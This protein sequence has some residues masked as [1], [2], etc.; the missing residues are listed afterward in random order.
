MLLDGVLLWGSFVLAYFLRVGF[1]FS[2]DVVF[3]PYALVS[4]FAS[5]IWVLVLML[6]RY[7]TIPPMGPRK[8]LLVIALGGACATGFL[9]AAYF[10]NVGG[11]FSRL[12]NLYAFGFGVVA[13]LI[14]D[15]LFRAYAKKI[16][17]SK[18]YTHKTLII[19][20]NRIAER[21][22]QRVNKD[23]F[24]AYEFVGVLAPYGLHKNIKGSKV[25]GKLNM[26]EDICKN[27]GVTAVIQCD[28]F[29]H[30]ISI[31]SYC[32]ENNIQFQFVPSLRGIFEENLRIRRVA[33][34]QM[35]SF[36]QRDFSGKKKTLYWWIDAALQH[37]FDID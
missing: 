30:T 4:F 15:G 27:E 6:T 28:G 32:D 18:K 17:A 7:Y 2:T 23:P 22:I 8:S 14:T 25:L 1:I 13:L 35:I 26:F 24:A 16:K 19:G 3:E 9:L 12:M 11:F 21:I 20:A 5:G 34:T 31:I 36:V 10:F 29:E 37:V 33:E